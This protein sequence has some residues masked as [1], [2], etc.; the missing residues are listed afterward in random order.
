MAVHTV[1]FPAQNA[2]ADKI[3]TDE[4]LVPA[5][6]HLYV[7][8]VEFRTMLEWLNR[9]CP[10]FA[11]CAACLLLTTSFALA[12]TA[13]A[14]HSPHGKTIHETGDP[15]HRV[16][17]DYLDNIP[18][19]RAP[20]PLKAYIGEFGLWELD[21]LIAKFGPAT[22]KQAIRHYPAT[23]FQD[24]LEMH[25]DDFFLVAL[26]ATLGSQHHLSMLDRR[27]G[28]DPHWLADTMIKAGGRYTGA[29]IIL[30]TIDKNHFDSTTRIFADALPPDLFLQS[31]YNDPYLLASAIRIFSQRDPEGKA[32]KSF[33]AYFPDNHTRAELFIQNLPGLV[34]AFSTI[35]EIMA[36][37]EV[38]WVKELLDISDHQM[39]NLIRTKPMDLA[40]VLHG[41]HRIGIK[42][43]KQVIESIGREHFRNALIHHTA[44]LANFL[45]GL[46]RVTILS[47]GT[48]GQEITEAKRVIAT[49]YPFLLDYDAY[50]DPHIKRV[51]AI[52]ETL[53][54]AQSYINAPDNAIHTRVY[55][56]GLLA[57]YQQVLHQHLPD[58]ML[59]PSQFDLLKTQIIY[60][61]RFSKNLNNMISNFEVGRLIIEDNGME[62]IVLYLAHELAHQILIIN[63]FNPPLL[64]AAS[65]HEGT[66]DIATRCIAQRLGYSTGMAEYWQKIIQQ[67][68]QS[69]DQQITEAEL[70]GHGIPHQIGRTQ[71]GYLIQAFEDRGSPV[72]WE[73]LF[74]ASSY[75]LRDKT[76]IK[77]LT[78]IQN[79]VAGYIYCCTQKGVSHRQLQRFI[80]SCEQVFGSDPQPDKSQIADTSCVEE[81]INTV[82]AQMLQAAKPYP[83][84]L[85][86]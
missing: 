70:I 69:D 60:S 83:S 38:L 23:R 52:F 46:D 43:F 2:L 18:E 22:V 86:P 74:A 8:W 55:L 35:H 56:L 54:A 66:A 42:L 24:M 49:Q 47:S 84:V 26:H 68:D 64:S 63:G 11:R 80:R 59:S 37:R 4:S 58:A 81:I 33:L 28:I 65:I 1:R 48:D 10:G 30:E 71:L 73:T 36:G 20:L 27:F 6:F 50:L 31:F 12:L 79:L 78:Y 32:L 7:E 17:A 41:E 45:T 3:D 77:H 53:P 67:D 40:Y 57:V 25:G 61:T 21:N 14:H 44:W 39:A 75:V 85:H 62:A 29:L 9:F 82:Q 13:C 16:L 5:V 19:Q 34:V 72:D 15:F 76:K 51:T